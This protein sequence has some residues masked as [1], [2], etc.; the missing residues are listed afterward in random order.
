MA[1][2][3]V[4]MVLA[5]VSVGIGSFQRDRAAE[6]AAG[7]ERAFMAGDAVVQLEIRNGSGIPGLAA[8]LS[9]ILGRAGAT[10]ALLA[11]ADHDRYQHSLLVNRRLDDASAHA[12]AARLGGLPVLM[13]FDPA[14]AA[15]AVLIL[16]NDHDRI[17]T[18]LL[19]AES[20][21]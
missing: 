4:I 7:Q 6:R 5:L 11:N 14:A 10:A 3:L 16:G 2:L 12:L 17:R 20:V 8:D 13:E 19:T 15:D 1:T 9:L 21:H 18:A